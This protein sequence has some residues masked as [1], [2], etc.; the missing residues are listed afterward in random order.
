MHGKIVHALVSKIHSKLP[1]SSRI[2]HCNIKIKNYSKQNASFLEGISISSEYFVPH[3]LKRRKSVEL[4][5]QLKIVLTLH[6]IAKLA[7]VR[8]ELGK[9]L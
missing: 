2:L 7:G 3:D 6:G 5:R 1:S 8:P 9:F 4:S